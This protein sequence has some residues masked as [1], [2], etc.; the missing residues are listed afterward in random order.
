MAIMMSSRYTKI[1][2]S[3]FGQNKASLNRWNVIG[4]LVSPNGIRLD[5]QGPVPGIRKVVY[6]L[7]KYY[8]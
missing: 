4:L 7:C 5:C 6:F 8:G 1:F 3:N 2:G